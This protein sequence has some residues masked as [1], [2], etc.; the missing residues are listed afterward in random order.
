VTTPDP[1]PRS[2]IP[3][4]SGGRDPFDGAVGAFLRIQEVDAAA[5]HKASAPLTGTDKPEAAGPNAVDASTRADARQRVRF[6]RTWKDVKELSDQ[7]AAW[8][9]GERRQ[10]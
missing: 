4:S 2:A 7:I 3:S 6:P 9:L 1:F 5:R 10:H 8:A